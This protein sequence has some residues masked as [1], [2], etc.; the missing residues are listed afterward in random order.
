MANYICI[1]S[2]EEQVNYLIDKIKDLKNSKLDKTDVVQETG[3]GTDVVMS[4]KA[5]TDAIANKGLDTL[6]DVNLTLGNTTV[7]YDTTNGIQINS[8]ARFTDGVGNHDATME[9]ALPVVGKDGIVIEKAADSE[10]IEVSGKNFV[11]SAADTENGYRVYVLSNHKDIT[12]PLSE[13]PMT[14]GIA[15]YSNSG[16]LKTKNPTE[17]LDAANKKYVDDNFLKVYDLGTIGPGEV[18]VP[19]MRNTDGK[20]TQKWFPTCVGE[21]VANSAIA[22]TDSKG[23]LGTNTPT[24]DRHCAN[25]KY[26]DD[27]IASIASTTQTKWQHNIILEGTKDGFTFKAFLSVCRSDDTPFGTFDEIV[28]A[29]GSISIPCTGY[30]YD[31]TKHYSIYDLDCSA[32]VLDYLNPDSG[33]QMLEITNDSVTVSD[34]PIS[35]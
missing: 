27:A 33:E 4:Q 8:T 5:V 25:K 32:P 35:F 12:L 11:K 20:N 10:K 22:L 9:L 18:K 6:T 21:W 13:T 23:H 15:Q 24:D 2:V 29:F 7:Q 34:D 19:T 26:V 14:Y 31:G 16:K 28:N 3:T 17:D 1:D 30:V